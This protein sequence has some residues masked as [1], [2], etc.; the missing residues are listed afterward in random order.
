MGP[1]AAMIGDCRRKKEKIRFALLGRVPCSL[2]CSV[3]PQARAPTLGANLG[4]PK[5]HSAQ[6]LSA[7]C[8]IRKIM[9][10]VEHYH[11]RAIEPRTEVSVVMLS[12]PGHRKL[13]WRGGEAKHPYSN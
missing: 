11:A 6:H 10:H 3:A 8:Y 4:W 13:A 1:C 7:T 5:P 2:P 12:E 9:F